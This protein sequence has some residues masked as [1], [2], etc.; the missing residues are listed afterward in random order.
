MERLKRLAERVWFGIAQYA[1]KFG[2]VGLIGF[3]ID[4]ALFNLLRLGVFGH[5]H[6]LQSPI[7]AKAV[8]VS[9]AIVFNWIGNRYWTFREHRRKNFV[10]ELVEYVV[11]SLGGMG[12]AL[13]CL[14]ISHYVLGYDT[15]L[16]DNIASNVIGLGLGT[17]FRFALYRYWVYGH[18]R[19][20]GLASAARVEE[21]QRTIFEE[22]PPRT[23]TVTE[24]TDRPSLG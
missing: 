12:I 3:G 19:K 1:L 18:H 17:L 8:S 20:D 7:G 4:I 14:Y 16:A 13:L 2:V 5:D 24:P 6:A 23:G 21:A 10:L 15:L 22:P 9:V 11:V